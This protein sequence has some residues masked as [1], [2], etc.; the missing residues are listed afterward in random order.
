MNIVKPITYCIFQ[1]GEAADSLLERAR[2]Y[3]LLGQRKTAIFDFSAILKEHPKHV[4]ALCG[5]G[6]TYLMLN[7]QKV[8]TLSK[9]AVTLSLYS[10][11]NSNL[12]SL[13]LFTFPRLHFYTRQLYT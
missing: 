12:N 6:F 8:Q 11:L 5:R 4:Q 7:Q 13:F 1:G 2:C 9:Q 3:A 10:I